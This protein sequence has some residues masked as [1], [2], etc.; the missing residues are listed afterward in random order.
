[1]KN[2]KTKE[3]EEKSI[4]TITEEIQINE[5]TIL[6]IGDIIEILDENMNPFFLEDI[7]SSADFKELNKQVEKTVV[8]LLNKNFTSED[9]K[10]A[11]SY[12]VDHQ[13]SYAIDRGRR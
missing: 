10:R 1:M 6:E 3:L 2:I 11:Y 13:Y 8:T 12:I 4:F 7:L 9:I 5:D